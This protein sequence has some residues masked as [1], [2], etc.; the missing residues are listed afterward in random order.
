MFGQAVRR[1]GLLALVAIVSSGWL[2]GCGEGEDD[3]YSTADAAEA[4]GVSVSVPDLS[5][6]ALQ[7]AELFGANCSECH[8]ASAGGSSQGPPLVDKIYEPGHH[9]DFSFVR[10]V[11]VGSPQHH[12]QFGD[13]DPV[14][15]L[16][17]E[18]VNKII[19]YV[20]ELQYAN[21]IFA[22]PAGLVACQG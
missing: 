6:T 14:P 13:M 7:G 16:S 19:C 5:D 20:R 10:A 4:P 2:A 15:G 21:G 17:P 12:W 22:D 8:G 3:G 9:A 11:E 1:R 18:E